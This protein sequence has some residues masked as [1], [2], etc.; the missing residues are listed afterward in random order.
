MKHFTFGE[1]V[2]VVLLAC[3][4]VFLI[5][6]LF[7]PNPHVSRPWKVTASDLEKSSKQN[8]QNGLTT[9]PKN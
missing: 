4:I 1:W 8:M 9:R 5:W 2:Q 6:L 7:S 3:V